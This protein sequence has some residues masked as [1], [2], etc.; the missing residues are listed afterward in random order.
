MSNGPDLVNPGPSSRRG[1]RFIV[2]VAI[3]CLLLPVIGGLVTI[4]GYIA[5]GFH[6]GS[7]NKGTYVALGMLAYGLWLAYPL[8]FLPA[9]GIG[10]I[11]ASRDLFG[12]TPFLESAALGGGIGVLWAVLA[13]K[14][15]LHD[16]FTQ[17]VV[18]SALIATVVCWALTRW[19]RRWA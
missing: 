14:W 2:T 13:A 9:A 8:G 19:T 16:L 12:G 1:L 10:A 18:A 3:F 15:Q 6:I 17:L 7:L 5:F 11:V 4:L